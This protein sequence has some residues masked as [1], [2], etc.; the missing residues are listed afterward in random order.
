M[1]SLVC[2]ECGKKHLVDLRAHLRV[3]K[4]TLREYNEKY[5]TTTES[6]NIKTTLPKV[7][8]Q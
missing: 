7:L 2:K 1:K 5:G 4:M 8:N 3:H 6:W